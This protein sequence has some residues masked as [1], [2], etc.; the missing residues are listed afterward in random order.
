MSKFKTRITDRIFAALL[1]VI[2][3]V[4]IMPMATLPVIAA[5]DANPSDFTITVKDGTG[6][7]IDG[8]TV[9]YEIKLNGSS[10]K[11]GSLSTSGGEVA[12]TDMADYITEI[13]GDVDEITLS[14]EVSKTD[15]VSESE[16]DVVV[17]DPIG[18]INVTLGKVQVSVSVTGLSGNGTATL[19]GTAYTGS[20][21]FDK[22]SSVNLVVTPASGYQVSSVVIDGGAPEIISNPLSFSKSITV[23]SATEIAVSFVK[24]WTFTVSISANGSIVTSPALGVGGSVIVKEDDGI[25]I[26]ATPDTNYR[27][28]RVIKNGTT[29]NYTV[30][31][32]EY[33]DSIA[34]VKQD[35]TYD[36]TFALNQYNVTVKPY[37]NG[38]V[39][40]GS[41]KVNYN[42][43]TE[44]VF[45]PASGYDVDDVQVNGADATLIKEND[46]TVK[47]E[48]SNIQEDKEIEVTFVAKSSIDMTDVSFNNSAAIRTSFTGTT[49]LYV[50]AKGSTVTFTTTQN[51][52]RINGQGSGTSYKTKTWST[53][54]TVT[55]NQIELYYKAAGDKNAKWHVVDLEGKSIRIVIDSTNPT[56]DINPAL[57]NAN[58]YYNDNI[59]VGILV[60]D[61]GEYSGINTVEYW[62]IK[63]G[64]VTQGKGVVPA[65]AGE[66]MLYDYSVD[67]PTILNTY[68]DAI[69]VDAS[70]NNSDEVFVHVKVTDRAGNEYTTGQQL[71]IN[72]TPPT[73]S[74]DIGGSLH[75]D[76]TTGYYSA[77]RT[78]TITI[79][80][81]ATTFDEAAAT[82]G[83]TINAVNSTGGAVTISKAAM[84]SSW[85][86]VGDSHTATITFSTDANYTWSI[87]Y[88][89]KADVSNDGVAATGN[90]VYAFTI[91][92]IAPT[93]SIT[94]DT[95]T[96]NTIASVLTFGLWKNYSVT[97]TASGNDA[98]S[99]LY[100]VE[101]YKSNS[102]TA[103]LTLIELE[104]LY[105]NGDFVTSPFT[106]ASDENFVVYARITDYAGNALYIST[107][108]LIVDTTESLITLNPDPANSEG[109]Y[110]GNVDVAISVSDAV[111][112]GTAYSGIKT[113]D[114]KVESGGSTTQSGNLYT[115]DIADPTYAQL[116]D[117]W[118]GSITVLSSLNNTD[119]TK[120]TV[121]VY[122][123]AGNVYEEDVTLA[124]NTDVPTIAVSFTDTA[125]KVENGRGYFGA[126]RTATVTIVDRSSAFDEEAATAGIVISAVNATGGNVTLNTA[127]MISSWSH[128]GN[129]HTATIVFSTDGNYTWSLSYT[130]KADN[131]NEAVTTGVSVT[132]YTFA[133]DKT[134]PSGTITVKTN[135]WDRLLEVLTFGLYS[136][137]SVDVS[138]TATDATSPVTIEYYK[139][140]NTAAMT[141]TQL[142]LVTFTA[143]APFS[144]SSDERFVV[145]LK[146]T[147]HAG[148]YIYI[149]SDGYI[150]DMVKSEI[151]LTPDTPNVNNTYNG[152]L[153]VEI[154]IVDSAPYSGIKSV[155]YWVQKDGLETQRETLFTFNVANPIHEQLV[156]EWNDTITVDSA[157]NNSCN[158]VVY[159]K[160]I[161]NAGNEETQSVP[162]DIDIT[163]P[164]ID[165]TYNNNNDNAGNGYLNAN[166]TATVVITERTHHFDAVAATNG[167]TITAVDSKGAPVTIDTSSM[168]SS[169]VTVE[170]ATP[171]AAKHTATITYATDANYTFSI[172]YIDKADNN[173][174]A[175]N[176]HDSAAPYTFTVDKVAPTGTVT[177]ESVEGR[178]TTWNDL[179]SSLTF[180][181]WSGEKITVTGTTDDVTSPVA[182]VL[183]YK[184]NATAALNATALNAI[185]DWA[186][187]DTLNVTPNEQ[188]TIYIKIIDNAGNFTY[189]STDGLIVDDTAPREESIAP[190][191]TVS[192][193]QP[194]NGL[195]NRDV[196]VSIKVDD[197]L[198]GGTYSG[199]KT[200]TYR[201]LNMGA[202]TQSGTLYSFTQSSP[203]HSDLLKTWTGE[204]TVDSSLN[205]SNDVVI[206]I[207]A[208]DN[209]LNSSKNSV[210]IKIDITAPAINISY[211]DNNPDSGKY[212]KNDRVATIVVTERNFRSE[213]VKVTITNTD[214]T[215]PAISGWTEVSGTGNLDNTTHTATIAYHADGDYTFAIEY[216][217]RANNKCPGETYSAGTATQTEFTIDQTQPLISVSY[218]NNTAANAKYFDANRT[219]TIVINEHN[220][221]VS[222]VR[223]T[224]TSGINGTTFNSPAASW[225]H[226]GDIHTATIVYDRDGDYTFDVAVTDMAGNE[227]PDADYGNTV[228]GKDFTIDTTWDGIVKVE[229]VNN[230]EV[231]GMN[232]GEI[233]PDAE[234]RI[235]FDDINFYDY[236][237]ILSRSRVMMDKNNIA[238]PAI[239]TDRD[240]T[241]LFVK[242]ATGSA[243]TSET[244]T[245]ARLTED[246][247]NDGLYELRIEAKDM[248]GNAYD[249]AAN[250]IVFSVN[251]F[252][253]VYTFNNTLVDLAKDGGAYTQSVSDR[254]II[255]EYNPNALSSA[256][257]E[258]TRDVSPISDIKLARPVLSTESHTSE[259]SWYEYAYEI[260]T[261]NFNADG[262]YK[263]SV[264]SKD[265]ATHNS[266]TLTYDALSV[267]FRVD[268]TAPEITNIT[269][270]DEAIVNAESKDVSFSLFDAIGLKKA[271]VYV[272]GSEVE[273]FDSFED[274]INFTGSFVIAEGA[275][276]KVRFVIEDMAGNILDTDEKDADGKY[277]FNPSF[278]FERNVTISTNFFVRY[279]ANKPLFWGSIG[280]VLML[281]IGLGV[282]F[283]LKK[284]KVSGTTTSK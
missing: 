234:I 4:G 276:Q 49:D 152:N 150:V 140:A 120:V 11:T 147:D 25:S 102:T 185:T 95:S 212:Y 93:G 172:S 52:I 38:T 245:I 131:S 80:D 43:S 143:F 222:R 232:N 228:A 27:V 35:Y 257:V 229:G 182:Q 236:R 108:G 283:F 264:S 203:T 139:T 186:A 274:L 262:V 248:A 83:I 57:A 259:K 238:V 65:E 183:Y 207:Y 279:Y 192:P 81:R 153:D 55:I 218:N 215:I 9:A 126:N 23:N 195:Y 187:F 239:E 13:E 15:Y 266:E 277:L 22:G 133:V 7:P 156:N 175:V 39:S 252:G 204:I 63:D 191:V 21:D 254:I 243:N 51:G 273:T 114:Y 99:P 271:S 106:V 142:D 20:R 12:I 231:L 198:V 200:I 202:Q 206:E 237:I 118:T 227:S 36:I 144:V 48:L 275:N 173:N 33:T 135:T 161:D 138:A 67:G 246:V 157:L 28:S 79:V 123:N 42:G 88:T 171:D 122:D 180:G 98:T 3:L 166:R 270:L 31:N 58:G 260:E 217:D 37:T 177:A 201:V 136:N 32:Y 249:T 97:T 29:T 179:V 149:N 219:A 110:N 282:F 68:S 267:E 103:I 256:N 220:F 209:A 70:K 242:N 91:D 151:T 170:G 214:G 210:A 54:S 205:N 167:I 129:I 10:V 59:N 255:T 176:T 71:K 251:R 162:L 2:M 89:N 247:S 87:D 40:I 169:W 134:N 240:V 109:F 145:Y 53:S 121:T 164:T 125:N 213:D 94:A 158:V 111:N 263:V 230:G 50:F 278:G 60:E 197:P 226:S 196:K 154:D 61:L 84:V 216:T 74:V 77:N 250:A 241:S 174:T 41:T 86:S 73:V 284:K 261:S 107:N 56:A 82:N 30:N 5:T 224:Q 159:V 14:Y 44:V 193:E 235:T 64:N 16:D 189:I 184:T 75:A 6:T 258:I 100:D 69:I 163:A 199:L 119:D 130:N 160:T 272:N 96:W 132:P 244:I 78:A 117:T 115:F 62:V 225:S 26:T 148:N 34:E 165:L 8:A 208:E 168:I 18:N 105:A 137:T 194:I 155:E 66:G 47:I 253:S 269:G 221:D 188:F 113:I 112:V 141:A 223:F 116:K 178:T 101:Y 92:K 46:D 24:I 1:A 127:S 17:T 45:T 104:G 211:N 268:T 90:S 19:N 281:G 265:N 181:F 190:E 146:I 128:N 233:D 76:A 85:T 72:T 124:I 280:G